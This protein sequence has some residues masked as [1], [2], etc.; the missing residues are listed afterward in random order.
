MSRMCGFILVLLGVCVCLSGCSR[1]A[2]ET[3][4]T[5][6]AATNRKHVVLRIG[7]QRAD[8]LNLLKLRG[9]LEKR[10]A[11]AGVSVEWLNFTAGLPLLE[12]LGVGSIDIGSTGD[13]P[14]L[15]AQ[16]AGTPLVYIA[17]IPLG[18]HAE[19]GEA[20]IVPKNSPIRSVQDLKGKKIA[21]QK[22]SGSHNLLLQ[23]LQKAGIA[24][25]DIQP[26]YLAPPDARVAFESGK[27]DAWVVW[28][29][30]LAVAIKQS[31][32]RI[33]ANRVG[34]NTPGAFYLS[35]RKF[36]EE[37]PELIKIVLE[38]VDRASEWSY[39]HPQETADLLARN[40]GVDKETLTFLL[41][42]RSRTGARSIDEKIIAAQQTSADNFYK[43]GLLPRKIDVREA[44]LTP[45]QYALLAPADRKNVRP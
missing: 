6:V 41:Q 23:H 22:A 19:D 30:F 29:P 26:L 9:D 39:Q 45:A 24:Y 13:S 43:I 32:A 37:H 18:E 3:A 31:G 42:R 7:H 1:P 28:D 11:P 21:F 34:I 4:A 36:A 16:A 12:A 2:G 35:S 17:N 20:I 8:P 44:T 25:S 14:A 40:T 33:I 15:F 5:G 27:I 10:L 38:E